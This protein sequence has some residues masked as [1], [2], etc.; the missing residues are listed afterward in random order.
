MRRILV[1]TVAAT[2]L[3]LAGCGTDD[4]AGGLGAI[5][6]STDASPRSRSPRASRPPRPRRKVL[7]KGSGDTVEAGDSVKVNYV[8]VNGRTGKQFDSSFTSDKPLTLTLDETSI[9]PGFIKGLKDQKIGSRVLV[10]IPP[11]DG[12]GQAQAELDMKNDDTMV[13]LF[14]LVAKVPDDGTG[15]AK[16]L[17][18]DLP[19]LELDADKQPVQ[20]HEDQQRPRQGRPRRARTS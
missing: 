14:D 15:K 8:A 20:V 4:S 1:A 11:K 19:K 7:K 12:F 18:K 5:K 13:F 6:V 3:L 10:A 2:S 17:P 9:L 16:A